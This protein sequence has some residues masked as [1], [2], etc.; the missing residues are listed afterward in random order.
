M[1]N[2]IINLNEKQTEELKGFAYDPVDEQLGKRARIILELANGKSVRD[3]ANTV[4]LN[5]DAVTRW[6]NRYLKGGVNALYSEHGGGAVSPVTIPDLQ[7]RIKE[8]IDAKTDG[9]WTRA[10]L[11]DNL[12]IPRSTLNNELKK[13]GIT[14]SRNTSWEFMTTDELSARSMCIAGLYISG[15]ARCIVLCTSDSD[16][17]SGNE[18]FTTR[19]RHL[20][21]ELK[22]VESELTLRD[23]LWTA[24]DHADEDGKKN[25]PDV[26][27]FLNDIIE[28]LPTAAGTTCYAIGISDKP[29]KYRGKKPVSLSYQAVY[30]TEEWETQVERTF[31]EICAPTEQAAVQEIMA[32]LRKFGSVCKAETDPFIWKKE[33]QVNQ[34]EAQEAPREHSNILHRE[35]NGYASLEEAILDQLNQTEP[36]G[37]SIEVAMIPVVWDKDGIH[38]RVVT[39]PEKF[40][41]VDAFEFTSKEDFMRGFNQME[42]PMILLRNEAGKVA[43]ELFIDSVKKN[44]IMEG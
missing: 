23:I 18:V 32:A 11:A 7:E 26:Q 29:L 2:V 36:V 24:A 5:K 37:N 22:D 13:M 6:K 38:C 39:I 33:V 19:N 17:F 35:T 16:L 14:L 31:R 42:E 40:P 4:G 41:N 9:A 15:N 21:V 44:S 43:S 12:G 3:V 34:Y 25:P 1:R 30:T 8:A 20:A 28:K 10:G 27:I